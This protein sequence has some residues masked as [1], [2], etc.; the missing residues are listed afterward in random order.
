MRSDVFTLLT[1]NKSDCEIPGP[2]FRGILSPPYKILRS[3]FASRTSRRT[4][5]NIYDI[6]DIVCQLS[7]VVG[8]EIISAT[9]DKQKLAVVLGLESFQCTHIRTYVFPNRSVRTTTCFYGKNTRCR[10]CTILDQKFLVLACKNVIGDGRWTEGS[11]RPA[12]A[13]GF[14]LPILY[15][16]LSFWHRARVKAV[17]PE[18]TGLNNGSAR[19]SKL[20]RDMSL[21]ADTDSKSSL[22]KITRRV[23][24]QVAIGKLSYCGADSK[25]I[26]NGR[27]RT[28]ARTC[29]I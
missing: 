14:K 12:L 23:I 4:Y 9:F 29:M 20:L 5:G 25:D 26:L 16:F 2:P 18:P 17:L 1:I 13:K 7:G 8:R 6:D 21:P 19:S 15:S 11:M 22:L 28:G 3:T 24:R 27:L 10:E